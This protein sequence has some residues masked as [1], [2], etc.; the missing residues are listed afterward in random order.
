[1]SFDTEVLG[2]YEHKSISGLA[3]EVDHRRGFATILRQPRRAEPVT[4]QRGMAIRPSDQG[5][6][7]G[8][9]DES[10]PLSRQFLS[11]TDV[12][13]TMTPKKW[14]QSRALPLRVQNHV[15]NCFGTLSLDVSKSKDLLWDFASRRCAGTESERMLITEPQTRPLLSSAGD[16]MFPA[17][18]RNVS[19]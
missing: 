5:N 14:N 18:G 12:A 19:Q 17:M 16:E 4:I 8:G 9:I 13:S 10:H 11:D 15:G 6:T 7:D 3:L 1:M 2:N